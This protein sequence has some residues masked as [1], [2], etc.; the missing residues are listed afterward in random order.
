M[1]KASCR[2]LASS[3]PRLG[4]EMCTRIWGDGIPTL[5]LEMRPNEFGQLCDPI[6]VIKTLEQFICSF[7]YGLTV[8]IP[9]FHWFH[10]QSHLSC[11]LHCRISPEPPCTPIVGHGLH[12]RKI[13]FSSKIKPQGSVAT[14]F[15]SSIMI[16]P[17]F[18]ANICSDWG[19]RTQ[20]IKITST[21]SNQL[22]IFGES[23]VCAYQIPGSEYLNKIMDEGFL[24]YLSTRLNYA[25]PRDSS[26]CC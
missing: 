26:L 25:V 15:N 7:A 14:S 10:F 9:L 22:K 12:L 11:F 5:H 4:A 21:K 1:P 20:S 17:F 13:L 2:Y 16:N 19:G 23:V 6:G 24:H 3:E 8:K 18:R